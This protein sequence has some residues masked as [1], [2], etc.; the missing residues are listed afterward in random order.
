MSGDIYDSLPS[1]RSLHLASTA[2]SRAELPDDAD[3]AVTPKKEK[4]TPRFRA[5]IARR[6]RGL[7]EAAARLT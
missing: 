7:A 5:A 2:G 3:R 4:E 6:V 1:A